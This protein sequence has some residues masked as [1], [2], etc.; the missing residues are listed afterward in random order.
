MKLFINNLSSYRSDLEDI[1]IKNELKNK[2]NHDPRRQD[3]F[4]HL[5]LLGAY[6]LKEK[7]DMNESDELYVTSGMGNIEVLMSVY[8]YA[9]KGGSNIKPFD[10]INILGNTTSFYIA[11]ALDIKGKTLFQISERFT[12]INT[13]I[14]AYASIKL[15]NENAVIACCDLATQPDEII[16]RVSGVK[17]ELNLVSSIN[18]QRVSLNKE[19]SI[20]EIEFDTITYSLNEI[21]EIINHADAEV[22]VSP[23]CKSLDATRTDV[24]FETI[25]SYMINE[26]IQKQENLIFVDYFDD[27]YKILRLKSYC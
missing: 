10:F 13:L 5:G 3:S 20:A 12:Y 16:K 4:I 2:Y 25:G 23:R 26:F 1:S 18:F 9:I 11:R 21:R 24:F 15:S 27:K 17:Q 6:R 14:F 8:K 22:I 19:D 7:S